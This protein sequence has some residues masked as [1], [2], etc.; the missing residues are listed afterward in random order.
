MKTI[1]IYNFRKEKIVHIPICDARTFE[2]EHYIDHLDLLIRGDYCPPP[3]QYYTKDE[4]KELKSI[5]LD[6][7]DNRGKMHV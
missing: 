1:G 6:E 2:L 4:A 7:L 3:H 5:I